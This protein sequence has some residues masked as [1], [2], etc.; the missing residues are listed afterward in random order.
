MNKATTLSLWFLT[1]LVLGTTLSFAQIKLETQN[2]ESLLYL[3]E[4]EN[5]PLV[6]G[7]G[8]SEGGNAWASDH[9]KTT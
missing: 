2:T 6:V 9:W 5:Q 7:L 1:I 8:G 3:G 4:S